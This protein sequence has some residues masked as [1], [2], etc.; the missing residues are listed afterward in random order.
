M[1]NTKP[2]P[3]HEYQNFY[4]WTSLE[5]STMIHPQNCEFMVTNN[6]MHLQ[7]NAQ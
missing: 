1:E 7:S 4:S 6:D 5:Y 2:T 3:W